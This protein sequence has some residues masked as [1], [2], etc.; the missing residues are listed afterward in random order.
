MSIILP[1]H[2]TPRPYQM[3][4]WKYLAKGGLRASIAWHRRSGKDELCLH[5]AACASQERVGGIWHLLPE[6]S[7]ARKSIWDA[8]NPHTG[9]RRI[10]EAFPLELRE[11][12]RENEMMIKFKNG[13]TWQLAGSDNY[14]ALVGSS[15]C[16]LVFSEYALASPSAW[17]YLR[18]IVL[19]NKG[20]AIFISTPRGRNHFY[21]LHQAAEHDPSWFRQSLSNDETHVFTPAQMTDELREMQAQHGEQFGQSFF[22]QEYHV[23]FDAAIMGSIWGDCVDQAVREK[24]IVDYAV[25]R[26]VPV[27][28][29]WD[30]GRTDDT[31]IWFYQMN[32]TKIDVF[33]HHASN[34]KD[35][36]FYLGLLRQKSREY[37]ITY[38]THW[39]PHD[40]RPRTLAAGG[41]SIWQQFQDGGKDLGRF[42]IGPRL[43]KQEG[44][45]AARKTFPHCRFHATRCEKGL[46]SLK[47]YHR[48]WD[49]EAKV[50]LQTPAHDAS[51][52]DAD[53]FR[54]LSLSW[55]YQSVKHTDSPI[56][57]R[58]LT[59]NVRSRTL[60]ALREAHLAK[61]QQERE[62]AT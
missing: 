55:R 8:V 16:G 11:V 45:Q 29:A 20:W 48:E 22:N 61:R 34:T 47:Q 35:I 33:D 21:D 58:L 28:T 18:P 60:G 39:L 37:G 5:H 2:W 57:D 38:A 1:N 52:H 53:A 56:V 36:P 59:N 44:I 46:A 6:Y 14:N 10:D 41:K 24:R 19:E 50:F 12:T 25:D 26:T 51:S 49:A 23:S 30:L 54:Y 15:P 31:A 17:A 9:K 4:L 40:A 3:A 32:G 13:S 42:S 7:Q 27:Y 62:W 43:D